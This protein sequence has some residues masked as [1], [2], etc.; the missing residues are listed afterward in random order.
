MIVAAALAA[1]ALGGGAVWANNGWFSD[2]PDDHRR[3]E[4][5]RYAKAEGLFQGFPDGRF[6]PDA[7]LSEGQFIKV[8]ERL[9]DRYDIWTRAEW[10]QV[11]YAGVPGLTGSPAT[12]AGVPVTTVPVPDALA[13]G[14]PLGEAESA[15][16]IAGAGPPN[17]Q[18]RFP[19]T[20]CRPPVSYRIEFQGQTLNLPYTDN[21]P[22]FTP[23][24]TWRR[25]SH[26]TSDPVKVTEFRPGGPV[27]GRVLG[28]V[29]VPWRAVRERTPTT[30]TSTIPLVAPTATTTTRPPSVT[31]PPRPVAEVP[32]DERHVV[33]H[34]FVYPGSDEEGDTPLFGI[35]VA[36]PDGPIPLSGSA[37]MFF[38]INLFTS[39]GEGEWM[40]VDIY[41]LS[42]HGSRSAPAAFQVRAVRAPDDFT[43]GEVVVRRY[44][45][46]KRGEELPWHPF[47]S[48]TIHRVEPPSAECIDAWR[49]TW[50][51]GVIHARTECH[52]A[53]WSEWWGVRATTG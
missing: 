26:I 49:N 30:P 22:G 17:L 21:A 16:P 29:A 42:M 1:A 32:Y 39:T 47:Q 23:A 12:T 43:E 2:V 24:F 27:E 38:V 37:T 41:G 15:S 50:G 13:C 19:I 36:D 40:D 46:N 10:A 44:P 8:A 18:F 28:E 20:P 31:I 35:Y 51:I 7:E 25:A 3:I 48:L 5:I 45:P 52:P 4:A 9:Y 11:L 53:E 6:G 34:W 33:V 14:W